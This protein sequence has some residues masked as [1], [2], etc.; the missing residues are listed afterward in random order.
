MGNYR[1]LSQSAKI[2][3]YNLQKDQSFRKPKILVISVVLLFIPPLAHFYNQS[4][5]VFKKNT[6][7]TDLF[8]TKTGL[9]VLNKHSLW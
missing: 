4:L 6:I 9:G 7:N 2:I 8:K 1:A 5:L 3:F